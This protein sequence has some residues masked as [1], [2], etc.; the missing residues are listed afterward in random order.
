MTTGMS[1]GALDADASGRQAGGLL[2][3]QGTAAVR[4]SG[5]RC[6]EDRQV[7]AAGM[8]EALA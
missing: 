3:L 8:L 6:Y 4:G 5:L 7:A 2:T 1:G